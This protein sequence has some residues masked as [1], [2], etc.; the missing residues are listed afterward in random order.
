VLTEA[1][2]EAIEAACSE[3]SYTH[4]HILAH[5]GEYTEGYDSRF[6]LLLH[7]SAHPMGPPDRVSGDRLATAL[8]TSRKDASGQLARPAVV[9]LASCYGGSTGSVTGVGASIAHALHADGIPMVIASQF[10]LSFGA[11]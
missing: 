5:G 3:G 9:T 8:R 6:G 4:V 7:D 2:L 10:P 1:S 11:Q